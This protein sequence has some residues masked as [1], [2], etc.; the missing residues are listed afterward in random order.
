M[1]ALNFC[2]TLIY[3]LCGKARWLL[4]TASILLAVSLALTEINSLYRY[5]SAT[6]VTE[7]VIF[8][9]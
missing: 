9:R 4:L 5:T 6:L 1:K 2:K 3:K 7:F 8:R